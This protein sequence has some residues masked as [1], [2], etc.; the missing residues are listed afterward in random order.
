[1]G[2]MTGALSVR[3]FRVVGELPDDF[4]NRFRDGLQENAFVEAPGELGKEEREGWVLTQNLLDTDFTDFNRWLFDPS[5]VLF[6]LRVDKKSL[7]G[8]LVKAMLAKRC[9]AWCQD[10]GVQRCPASTRKELLELLEDELLLKT[11]PRIS[12]TEAVWHLDEQFLLLH[13]S[14]ETVTDRFRKR[15]FNTFGLRLVPWSPLDWLD[16]STEVED[17]MTANPSFLALED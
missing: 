7:P 16:S 11:L 4:R 9:E 15:F 13:S 17:M 2:I 14:S 3:R 12:V 10:R 8:N 1:M 5:Y 6:A